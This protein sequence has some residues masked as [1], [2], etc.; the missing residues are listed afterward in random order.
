MS[1]LLFMSLILKFGVMGLTRKLILSLCCVVSSLSAL[2]V[3]VAV[4][5]NHVHRPL[6]NI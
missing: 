1:E 4:M 2:A 3:S 6:P 5:N